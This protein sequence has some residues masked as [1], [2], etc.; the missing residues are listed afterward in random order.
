MRIKWRS[1]KSAEAYKY[2]RVIS[3]IINW[4]SKP[5]KYTK[6]DIYV[7]LTAT[8]AATEEWTTLEAFLMYLKRHPKLK[9]EFEKAKLVKIGVLQEY[10]T[11]NISNLL[12]WDKLEAKDLWDLSLKV[13]KATDK[14]FNPKQEIEATVDAAI[15]LSTEDILLRIE[16][17]TWK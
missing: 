17:L 4:S 16:E 6:K 9:A 13:L 5:N 3:K 10:A 11:D 8:E 15:T 2:E 7:P 12:T 14:L 1:G